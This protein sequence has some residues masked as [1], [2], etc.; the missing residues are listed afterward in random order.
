MNS[1]D[2]FSPASAAV[3]PGS[4]RPM[5]AGGRVFATL[6]EAFEELASV[7]G[8]LEALDEGRPWMISRQSWAEDE[9]E[10]D[11]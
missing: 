8:F 9:F 2:L 7:Q 11:R 5:A 4:A 6:A 10:D 3:S 1:L